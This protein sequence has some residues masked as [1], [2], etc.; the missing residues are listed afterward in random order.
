VIQL[1]VGQPR[2]DV[3]PVGKRDDVVVISVPP[4]N[5]NLHLLKAEAPIAG[6]HDDV[7]EW[8]SHLLAAAVEQIVKEHR[9]Y[10]GPCQ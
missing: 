9:L 5:G 10:F 6:E 2:D 4:A 3:L 7:G 1:G 8:R